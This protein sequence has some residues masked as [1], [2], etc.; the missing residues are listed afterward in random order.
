MA[1]STINVPLSN[2]EKHRLQGYT[3][4]GA[5]FDAGRTQMVVQ[6]LKDIRKRL[7]GVELYFVPG[8][9]IVRLSPV[10]REITHKLSHPSLFSGS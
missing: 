9:Q 6:D 2:S 3:L 4:D 10:R 7:S 5:C 1:I 8:G